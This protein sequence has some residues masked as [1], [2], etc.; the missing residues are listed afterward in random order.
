MA[1]DW[2]VNN[3]VGFN[4]VPAVLLKTIFD[5]DSG[6][7]G[8]EPPR[9]RPHLEAPGYECRRDPALRR[10]VDDGSHRGQPAA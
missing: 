7:S 4:G 1:W 8:S 10:D 9:P 3:P 6:R 5:L 2:F